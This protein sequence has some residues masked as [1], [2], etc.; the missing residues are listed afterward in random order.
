MGGLTTT[1]YVVTVVAPL[2]LAQQVAREIW[3]TPM[4]AAVSH[5]PVTDYALGVDEERG[6]G[7]LDLG[8]GGRRGGV[9]QAGAH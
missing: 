2:T 9:H 3:R 7:G 1:G 8:G 6:L 5:R 4:D